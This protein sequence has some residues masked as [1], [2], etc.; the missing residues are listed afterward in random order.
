M[1]GPVFCISEVREWA[2]ASAIATARPWHRVTRGKSLS[3]QF[4][5]RMETHC[6][7][8]SEGG[9]LL[10]SIPR[11]FSPQGECLCNL[12]IITD[13]QKPLHENSCDPRTL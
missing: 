7:I 10:A 4:P 1:R 3:R 5:V 13:E 8:A 6:N 2:D 9:H 11:L 12:K